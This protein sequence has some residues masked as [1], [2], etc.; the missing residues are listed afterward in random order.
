MSVDRQAALLA[1]Q[2]LDAD[3]DHVGRHGEIERREQTQAGSV[4][5]KDGFIDGGNA[6]L[7]GLR[8]LL[9]L[10]DAVRHVTLSN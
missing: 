6:D 10:L 3:V 2:D 7:G 8:F 9:R 1:A 4:L 5:L